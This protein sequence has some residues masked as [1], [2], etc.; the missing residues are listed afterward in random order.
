MLR[1][2]GRLT[3]IILILGWLAG[4]GPTPI[5]TRTPVT[6]EF[7]VSFAVEPLM[8][9]LTTAYRATRPHL[10][11]N[12]RYLNSAQA[13]DALWAGEVDLAAVSWL[14]E[15]QREFVWMTPIA[16]DGV[17]LI[18]HPSNPV[19]DLGLLQLRDLFRGRTAEWPDVGGPRGEVT[20][21][22]REVGSGT[23]AKFEETIME[24]RNVT[25]NAILVSSEQAMLNYVR[26]MTTS[27]G[28]VSTGNLTSTVKAIAVEGV[29]PTPATL[30]DQRYPLSR[31][32]LFVTPEEPQGELRAFVAWVLSP[33]GQSI[34][35]KKYGKVK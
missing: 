3:S 7:A 23:R 28:Y 5:A 15:A 21:I 30:A 2:R 32:L 4:C 31:P 33:E 20:V 29:Q 17:A 9:E 25:V 22:S 26:G 8:N 13:L 35:G 34:V 10:T 18:V 11:F 24:G 16:I 14:P 19:K 12:A 6:F 1:V 27:I